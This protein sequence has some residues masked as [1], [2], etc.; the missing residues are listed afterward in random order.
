MNHEKPVDSDQASFNLGIRE[1]EKH[2]PDDG[3]FIELEQL[4]TDRRDPE[5]SRY[6]EAGQPVITQGDKEMENMKKR[7]NRENNPSSEKV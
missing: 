2:E 3:K 4:P 5:E 1:V 7:I 6:N